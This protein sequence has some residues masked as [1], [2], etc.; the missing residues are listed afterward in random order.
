MVNELIASAM[1]FAKGRPARIG[2]PGGCGCGPMAQIWTS[3]GMASESTA[4]ILRPRRLGGAL[5]FSALFALESFARSVNATVVS[6]QAYDLLGSSQKVSELATLVSFIVL[7]ISLSSPLLLA[8]V[9]RRIGYSAGI[10]CLALASVALA[11]HVLWGQALGMILRSAGASLLNIT[12]SLYIMDHVK[13][14]DLARV[15]PIRL[16]LST[17][18][19][20]LGPALGV[21]LYTG[22]GPWAPQVLS[23]AA[24]AALLALFWYLRLHD[25]SI[26]RPGKSQQPNPLANV[27]RFVSQPRLR[28]AW[29]IAFGR[30]SFWMTFFVYGPLLMV[31]SGLGK[32]AGGW[33]ISASQVLLVGAYLFG[34]I[35][36]RTG[37]RVVIAGSLAVIAVVS[38]AAGT[39]GLARP[40]LAAGLLLT[41]ALFAAALDGVGG[42]PFLRAVKAR[43]RPGMAAVYR[44]Y[45]DISELLPSFI[46]A[47]ALRYFEIGSVFVILGVFEITVCWV[48]WRYLPKSL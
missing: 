8:R 34:R 47:L 2:L 4:E 36:R 17:F 40:Y 48:A 38:I 25:H 31:E 45:L 21:M 24:S 13:R 12:L 9:P 10:L 42:I 43:E 6:L 22:Q 41:G 26:I 7:T 28:L 11:L 46:F 1:P 16:A 19:W 39:A 23:I 15:E 35:A 33:L 30:S 3:H 14:S 18:S 32:L 37:V 29:L 5:T 27:R 20:M 44:T